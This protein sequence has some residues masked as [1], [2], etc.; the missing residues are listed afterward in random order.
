MIAYRKKVTI[1]N[2]KVKEIINYIFF[3]ALATIV[4]ILSFYIFDTIFNWQYLIANVISI[5]VSILFAY[6]T[7]K[8]F[9]FESKTETRQAL[10]QEFTSFISF[11]LLS[12]LIDMLVMWM[13]V[14]ILTVDSLIAKLFT[15]IIVVV[16]N[17][18]F[19]RFIIFK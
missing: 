8:I 19:S 4:N 1:L 5:I 15:Q 7:N 14:D 18:I 10:I 17:Y 6:V 13:L 12:G 9:V 2:E 3:G 16:L 11:R